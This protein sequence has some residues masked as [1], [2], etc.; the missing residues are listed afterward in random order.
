MGRVFWISIAMVVAAPVMA[1][2]PV[3]VGVIA[4][5]SGP[6][7]QWGAQFR[8]GIEVFLARH[9]ET[10]AGRKLTFI[11]RD[12]G[13]PKPDV[14]RAL[15]QELIANDKVDYLAGFVFTP[16][17]LAVA[18]L[19]SRANVPTVIFNAATSKI[20]Q[21]SDRFVRTSFTLWQVTAPLA[22]WAAGEGIKTVVTAVSDYNPGID[23]ETAFKETFEA[24]GGTVVDTIRM[25]LSTTDFAPIMTRVLGAA[26]DAVFGFLPAGPPTFAFTKAYTDNGLPEAGIGFVGTGEM[27]DET[28]LEALG[29][30]ALGLTTS[31]H[32]A[33]ALGG[34]N[35][36][37]LEALSGVRADAVANMATVG[38]YDGVQVIAAMVAAAEKGTDPVEAVRG[39]ALTSPRGPAAIDAE[40]R[41]VTQ[42]VYIRR[43]EKAGGALV[44]RPFVTIKAV[45]DLGLN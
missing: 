6:F 2:T 14:A 7:A 3:K 9:G 13:G 42:N 20:T 31:Y 28:T 11:Y 39:M 22:D 27:T 10:V 43:V 15:A 33:G 36:A 37:F 29:E 17:A 24:A 8:D 19:I 40:T 30:G 21:T 32:Y 4:P 26:P 1:Q 16:N 25:P 12:V 23:A 18:P 41:H 44:N 45:P 35:T 5:F 34:E 38:A